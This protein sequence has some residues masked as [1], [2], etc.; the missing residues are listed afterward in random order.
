MGEKIG[1]LDTGKVADILVL[2]VPDYLQIPYKLD[3]NCVE[4]VI[5]NGRIAVA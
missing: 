5:K 3:R 1:S 4:T 2:D